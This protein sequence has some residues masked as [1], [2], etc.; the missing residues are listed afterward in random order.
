MV[1]INN[2][3]G[4]MMHI[5]L[6]KRKLLILFSMILFLAISCTQKP[7][8]SIYQSRYNI[9]TKHSSVHTNFKY[10]G[11]LTG[12][13]SN[14]GLHIIYAEDNN[15]VNNEKSKYIILSVNQ[16]PTNDLEGCIHSNHICLNK[17]NLKELIDA[18]GKTIPYFNKKMWSETTGISTEFSLVQENDINQLTTNVEKWKPFLIYNFKGFE[19]SQRA[20]LF[21]NFKDGMLNLDLDKAK[22]LKFHLIL[23]LGMTML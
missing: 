20:Y 11:G 14:S 21:L 3:N 4:N 13:S 22:T 16:L 2:F 23:E 17:A 1:N 5:Y 19:H 8:F 10:L 12:Y 18:I 9:P 7:N 15:E 6:K